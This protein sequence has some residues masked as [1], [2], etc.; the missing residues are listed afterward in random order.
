M[1]IYI[2]IY[3]STPFKPQ[4][5]GR[6]QCFVCSS[7]GTGNYNAESV[8]Y[9][10]KCM[11]DCAERNIYKGES[12]SNAYTR[13]VKHQTDLNGRNAVNSPLWKHCRDT[14][15]GAMQEFKMNVTGTFKNDAMLRQISEAVQIE[16][17]DAGSL[18]NTRAEWNM[19]RVPRATVGA[20]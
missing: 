13:G 1:Y 4:R 12:A 19:T 9:A 10:I 20:M 2:Y 14:H 7:G 16:C 11:G 15:N 18:M 3:R 8:T 6:E 5:C 17:T